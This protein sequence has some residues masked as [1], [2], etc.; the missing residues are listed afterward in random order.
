MKK[1]LIVLF[2]FAVFIMILSCKKNS[3]PTGPV[4]TAIPTATATIDSSALVSVP[5]GT[6]TQTDGT[7][8][9]SHAISAFKMGK[10]QVTYDL[11]Y[12][13]YSWAIVNGYT[14][15][16][17]GAEGSNGTAGFPP[18]TAKYQPVTTVN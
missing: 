18:T 16:N 17:A 5:G 2:V 3:S 9:F 15:Q 10:Y 13:V 6:F 12:T 11:W 1:V 4:A 7:N 14:F 8:S